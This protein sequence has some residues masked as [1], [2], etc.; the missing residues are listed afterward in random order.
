MAENP[1][2]TMPPFPTSVLR[3]YIL[4][5]LSLENEIMS[6][7]KGTTNARCPYPN[8]GNQDPESAKRPCSEETCNRARMLLADNCVF[9]PRRA[10]RNFPRCI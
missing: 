2:V 10:R 9:R 4:K 6:D 8:Q 3:F 7:T 1:N 5:M